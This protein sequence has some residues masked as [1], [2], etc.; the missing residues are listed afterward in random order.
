MVQQAQEQQAAQNQTFLRQNLSAMAVKVGE[1]QAQLMRLDALGA[2]LVSMSGLKLPDFHFDQVPGR[3]GALPPGVAQKNLSMDDL[4]S[5]LDT[6]SRRLE[7]RGDTLGVL[8]SQLFD[9]NVKSKL[10]PTITPVDSAFNGSGFGL[11]ID[12]I[13]GMQAMHEGID[14][15]ADVGTP[16]H[17]AARGVVTYAEYHHQYGYMV[18][19][20]HGNDFTTR[21][22]HTSKMYVKVGD[23]VQRGQK[24]A[25]VGDTGRTTGP[26]LHFEV[27]YKGV[28]QNPSRFLQASAR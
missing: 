22:A 4:N 5:Q 10:M 17:A 13:T 15:I 7:S 16:I 2:R 27:R 3:G 9:A 6:L 26:H 1:M 11:R 18:E 20:D 23:F 25:Q 19:I 24:I 21:Y 12:P 8:E 14:F 28:A